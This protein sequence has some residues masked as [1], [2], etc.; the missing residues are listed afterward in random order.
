MSKR[1]IDF[2]EREKWSHEDE[3]WAIRNKKTGKW[4]TGT[5]YR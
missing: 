4:L 2:S 5:D 1:N 3:M